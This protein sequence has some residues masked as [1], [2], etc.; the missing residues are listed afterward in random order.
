[1]V[2]RIGEVLCEYHYAVRRGNPT[3]VSGLQ[4]AVAVDAAAAAPPPRGGY[5]EHV[6]AVIKQHAG[7]VRPVE[8]PSA[9][10][11]AAA[12]QPQDVVQ[13]LRRVELRGAASRRCSTRLSMG[14]T[15]ALIHSKWEGTL[16][17]LCVMAAWMHP[18]PMACCGAK[19]A[20]SCDQPWHRSLRSTPSSR[21]L[22]ASLGELLA[23]AGLS[24]GG[25]KMCS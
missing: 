23:V 25:V 17:K 3:P 1:M 18:S 24:T 7:M 15:Q 12:G 13:A 2:Q 5:G 10:A 4:L 8:Q 19:R 11:A 16:T 21:V 6:K 22:L 14:S 9:P 20:S